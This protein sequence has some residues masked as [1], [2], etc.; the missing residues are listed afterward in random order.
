MNAKSI[1]PLMR[2]ETSTHRS[3]DEWVGYELLGNSA[4]FKG[5]Y[6]AVHPGAWMASIGVQGAGTWQLYNLAEDPSELRDL[7]EQEP[8]IL[9]E[10]IALYDEYGE[11]LGIIDMP[12]DFNPLADLAGNE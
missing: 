11:S 8:E 1:L 6:K 10:L 5:D 12:A 2:G 3:E 4:L 7:S 9:A